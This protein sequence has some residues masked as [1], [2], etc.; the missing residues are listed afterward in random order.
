MTKAAPNHVAVTT[1][2]HTQYHYYLPQQQLHTAATIYNLHS[3]WITVYSVLRKHSHTNIF[4]RMGK[5]SH[6]YLAILR[7]IA[8]TTGLKSN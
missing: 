8:I 6:I 3:Y 4:F 2:F 7:E 5:N 1:T